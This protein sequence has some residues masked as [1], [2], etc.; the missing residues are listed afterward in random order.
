MTG[1]HGEPLLTA[2][3]LTV[4]T[5]AG[6]VFRPIDINIPAGAVVAVVGDPDSGKSSLLLALT[7]RMRGVRGELRVD[8][9]DG[10]AH[11]GR[12]RRLTSVARI[13]EL[14]VPEGSLS[15]EDCITERGLADACP[16][17]ARLANYLH[18]AGVLGLEAK[19]TTLYR[20]L[21]PADQTRAAIA[22]ATIQPPKIVVLDDFDH[23]ATL[24]DQEQLWNGLL[25]LA[26]EGITVIAATTERTTIPPEAMTIEMEAH[27]A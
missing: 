19:L 10:I 3:S 9:V 21:T 14:I 6:E 8:G 1:T 4:H 11:P 27:H 5:P 18:T 25:A 13:D 7:G 22:F 12:I 17:R 24:A 23:G 26:A 20:Q 2:T 16:A 15:I